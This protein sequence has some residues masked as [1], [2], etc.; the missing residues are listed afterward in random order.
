MT[1]EQ[2]IKAINKKMKA[3]GITIRQL[4]QESDY[5]G[6]WHALKGNSV[7]SADNLD[8]MEQALTRLEAT[9]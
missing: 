4:D 7:P 3:K 8:K 9:K 2:R 6:V 1:T 5:Q